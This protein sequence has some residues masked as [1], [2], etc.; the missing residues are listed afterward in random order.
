[1]PDLIRFV[2]RHGILGACIGVSFTALLLVFDIAQLR[3]LTEGSVDGT[4]A[5]LLLGYF[6]VITFAACQIGIA[7]MFPP[8]RAVDPMA[9]PGDDEM[10]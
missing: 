3:T 2:I 8:S 4:L 9:P 5:R 6:M 1:M 10:D 7:V